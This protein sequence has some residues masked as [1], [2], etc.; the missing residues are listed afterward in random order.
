MLPLPLG[1]EEAPFLFRGRTIAGPADLSDKDELLGRQVIYLMGRVA[2]G[3]REAIATLFDL[4]APTILGV[5]MHILRDRPAAEQIL[6][7]VFLQVWRE[8]PR[9]NAELLPPLPWVLLLARRRAADRSP[10]SL[11][12][13]RTGASAEAAS[14]LGKPLPWGAPGNPP[15]R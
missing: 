4:W 5:L 9:Y 7:E 2:A 15:Q 10:G 3:D 8:A 12:R 11:E 14:D 1:T 6:Q 13:G